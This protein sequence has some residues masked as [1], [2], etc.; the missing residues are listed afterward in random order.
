[1]GRLSAV[2]PVTSCGVSTH[3]VQC[4]LY[5]WNQ[6]R[7]DAISFREIGGRGFSR[8]AIAAVTAGKKVQA[9]KRFI[10]D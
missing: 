8:E 5:N 1:L 7:D 6:L 9:K 10:A 4:I 2:A 3:R